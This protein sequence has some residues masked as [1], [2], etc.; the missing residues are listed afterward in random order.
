MYDLDVINQLMEERYIT[1]THVNRERSAQ[2]D[3]TVFVF[4]F[5]CVWTLWEELFWNNHLIYNLRNIIEWQRRQKIYLKDY[6]VTLFL[7]YWGRYFFLN[8]QFAL[9]CEKNF[10]PKTS[11][12]SNF[13]SL[14]SSH[15]KALSPREASILQA[16]K[17]FSDPLVT[18]IRSK[19]CFRPNLRAMT[20]KAVFWSKVKKQDKPL[21]LF[22]PFWTVG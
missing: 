22:Q 17:D 14:N 1:T 19:R 7:L 4:F 3:Q 21:L 6:L 18:L 13:S 11:N 15:H 8:V 5:F 20:N 16:Q 12:V 10:V 2:P 9:F